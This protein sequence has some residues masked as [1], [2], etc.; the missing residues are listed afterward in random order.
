[1][2][3]PVINARYDRSEFDLVRLFH[4]TGTM[5]AQHLAEPEQLD[6]GTAYANSSLARVWDANQ[7]RDVALPPD[8]SPAQALELVA[9]HFNEQGSRCAAW[10]TNP[11]APREQTAPLV[12]H[13]LATGH[14][15]RDEDIL[16]LR[17]MPEGPIAQASNLRIIPAR[18]SYRHSRT[19]ALEAANECWP[20][21]AD[22]LAEAAVAHLDDPHF[23]A[24]V[25]LR[26]DRAVASVGVLAV[27]EL[28][29]V[30]NLYVSAEFRR[31]GIGRTMMSRA[32]EICA[33]S[34]FRHVFLSLA[35]PNDAAMTLYRKLGFEP[36]GQYTRYLAP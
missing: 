9:G 34:L 10:V 6:V 36:I 26:D 18:A 32:L 27:G 33:R 5:W 7:V 2:P 4:K 12:D 20:D 21:V 1:M 25:A 3:L 30:E 13:L 11:S 24:L 29:L 31:Q 8:L 17:R 22:Q 28:G 14:S 19:L 23:D 16:Y 35:P 15:R